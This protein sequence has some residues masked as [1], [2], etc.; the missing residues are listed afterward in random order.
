MKRI[1]SLALSFVMV[2]SLFSALLGSLPAYA[3]DLGDKDVFAKL[4]KIDYATQVYATPEEKL[5]TMT[6]AVENT[7]YALYIQEY[8]AEICVVDKQTGQMLF[9]NPYDAGDSS[10]SSQIK[11][12]LLSQVVLTYYSNDVSNASMNSFKN[13]AANEQILI[14]RIRSGLRVEYTIGATAKKNTVPRQIAKTRLEEMILKPMFEETTKSDL[15][16][17]EYLQ[18]KASS[19][20]ADTAAATKA[21]SFVYGRFFSFYEL[22]DLTDPNLTAREQ[23]AILESYPITAQMPIYVLSEKIKAQEIVQLEEYIREY[24]EYTLEDMLYDHEFVGYEL[25]DAS[26]AVFRLALEYTLT[27]DGFRVRLPAR[28]ISYDAATYSLDTIQVLPFLGAGRIGSA[29]AIRVDEG[30][31]FIPD[32]SGAIINF[33]QNRQRTQVSGT[34]YGSDFG[35]YK[36]SS[37]ASASYQTWRVPAYGTVMTSH[38]MESVPLVDDQ[39][40]PVL[41]AEGK[42]QTTTKE[43]KTLRQGYLAFM[44]EG[45]SLT[46]ID[47]VDGGPEHEYHSVYTTF[48]ARQTDSYPLDGITVTGGVAVYTKATD[49]RYVGNYT[50]EY[51]LLKDD[52]AN[53]M[54]MAK[55][56]RAY[57]E[58]EGVLKKAEQKKD[59]SLYLDLIGDIDTTEKFLG[60][61]YSTKTALT[62]FEDAKTI[63]QELR[64]AGISNQTIRYLGW[65]NGGMTAT[66]PSKLKVESALG[67]EKGLKELILDASENDNRIYLDLNFSYVNHIAKFDGFDESEETAKT[68]DGKPAFL[69]TYNPTVQAFNNR[70]A[71]V[72]SAA[73]I[74]SMYQKIT[75]KY[76][77]LF[78]D[79]EKTISVSTLGYALNSSQDEEV[80]M[81][82]EEAKEIT[83]SALEEIRASYDKVLLESGNYYTWKY[84]DTILNIPQDSSNR[85]TTSAEIPF[86]GIVLHGYMQ[87]TGEAI[88]LAG[89][90][91]YTLLKTIE[92]GG[93]AYFVIAYDKDKISQLKINGYSQYY[94]VEYGIWKDRIIEEYQTLNRVLAPLQDHTIVS[95]E[96]LDNRVVKVGYDNGTLIYL[97]YNNF[98]VTVDDL[99][100]PAMGFQVTAA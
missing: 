30:Y 84:A 32:G 45:E 61:P 7:R 40:N 51:R 9:S 5:E 65:M 56:F 79:T 87:Y 12:E 2:F 8:T 69:Q 68:I 42:E 74:S 17:E 99:N 36:S 70:V 64:E 35:F 89:D 71:Y 37:A 62:S 31:N 48:Y 27:D 86:L 67:G 58:K 85:N 95:H 4:A 25:A 98:G 44:T 72:V 63:M 16:F 39:G 93:N 14:K 92:N 19:D 90:Y 1:L 100:I 23:A 3:Q 21:E 60:V 78:G 94:A 24:T 6:L 46:R 66:A 52:D 91:E 41:D 96:I 18:L 97:N 34:V 47:A 33:D 88:N 38:L 53:Y 11:N 57:L 59:T 20:P 15:T 83:V 22:K 26:P 28:G 50:I 10:A 77:N 73:S 82:R 13:A 49:R 81:N 43:I 54:G 55:A 29:N 76:G 75:E 80:P